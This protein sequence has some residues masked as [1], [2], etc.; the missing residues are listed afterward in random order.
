MTSAIELS[1]IVIAWGALIYFT[2]LICVRSKSGSVGLPLG[3]LI[4]MTFLHIGTITYLMPG[5]SHLRYDANMYLFKLN[6]TDDMNLQGSIASFLTVV[7][8]FIGCAF[9]RGGAR[10]GNA[11]RPSDI[12]VPR[13]RD[14]LLLLLLLLASLGYF[15]AFIKISSIQSLFVILRNL[16]VT[17]VVLGIWVSFYRRQQVALSR[18]I[19]VA[20]AIPA[21]YLI[22]FGFF[23]YGFAAMAIVYSFWMAM[24]RPR[25]KGSRLKRVGTVLTSIYLSLS[26]FVSYME[27]REKLRWGL[28]WREDATQWDKITGTISTLSGAHLLNPFDYSQLDWFNVRLNQNI[29]IGRAIWWH[30]LYPGLN[31]KGQSILYAMIGWMPRFLWPDKPEMGGSRFAAVH[32]GLRFADSVAIAIGPT[33]EFVA[34]FGMIGSLG[35]GIVLGLVLRSLDRSCAISLRKEDYARFIR[36]YLIGIAIIAPT[37]NLFFIVAAVAASWIVG[38]GIMFWMRTNG[39]R[40]RDATQV[41]DQ[42][43]QLGISAERPQRVGESVA[44]RRDAK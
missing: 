5:Y 7:G 29:L 8:I 12:A 22:A 18:W 41:L 1:L 31:L 3:Y 25:A 6:Y 2:A 4:T 10:T 40:R 15:F 30:Q 43:E 20:A 11:E 21:I 37:S 33:F 38:T 32:T 28:L 39:G 27:V 9:V 24:P 44:G 34:N 36:N 19:M 13:S 35:G 26:L 17:V 16:S 14:S 42:W 23:S